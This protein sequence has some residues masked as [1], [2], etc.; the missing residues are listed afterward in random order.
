MHTT[1]DKSGVRK[2]IVSDTDIN[3]IPAKRM[4]EEDPPDRLT[5]SIRKIVATEIR[6]S[7]NARPG[8]P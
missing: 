4:W 2:P 6:S 1:S 3:K 5:A 8:P 7:N